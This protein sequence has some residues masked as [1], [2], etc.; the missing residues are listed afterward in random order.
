MKLHVNTLSLQLPDPDTATS[1]PISYCGSG[2]FS[3]SKRFI[4]W[5]GGKRSM[6]SKIV[7]SPGPRLLTSL[8][9]FEENEWNAVTLVREMAVPLSHGLHLAFVNR[10]PSTARLHAASSLH[11]PAAMGRFDSA[12]WMSINNDTLR[13]RTLDGLI[14]PGTHDSGAYDMVREPSGPRI[15]YNLR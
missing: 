6:R 11:S 3:N 10:S 9:R 1:R 5:K 13:H 4:S 8:R 14:L 2:C 7:E 12:N 15:P